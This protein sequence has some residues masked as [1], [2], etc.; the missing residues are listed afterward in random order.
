MPSKKLMRVKNLFPVSLAVAAYLLAPGPAAAAEKTVEIYLDGIPTAIS[1]PEDFEFYSVA[2]EDIGAGNQD[3]LRL[4]GLDQGGSLAMG[5]AYSEEG[6]NKVGAE[7][8]GQWPNGVVVNSYRMTNEYSPTNWLDFEGQYLG[9]DAWNL[10][11]DHSSAS[12]SLDSQS[13]ER[14]GW[15]F[16]ADDDVEDNPVFTASQRHRQQ[17]WL[18]LRRGSMEGG[19]WAL[20]LRKYDV[21][22]QDPELDDPAY[23]PKDVYLRSG[24]LEH[25]GRERGWAFELGAEYG[26][27]ASKNALMD[28]TYTDLGA[29]ALSQLSPSLALSLDASLRSVDARAQDAQAAYTKAGA[30]LDWELGDCVEVGA[31]LRLHSEADDVVANSNLR[32]FSEMSADLRYR[33]DRDFT[34]EARLRQRDFE[35]ERLKLEDQAFGE[36]YSADPP[37]TRDELE[38]YREDVT[39][40]SSRYELEARWRINC[41]LSLHAAYGEESFDSLPGSA[42]MASAE[43]AAQLSRISMAAGSAP[44]EPFLPDQR[45]WGDLR[46]DYEVPCGGRFSF[47]TGHNE[48]RN[49]P[50]ASGH[51]L[52]RYALNYSDALDECRRWQAG[53]SRVESSVDLPLDELDQ[54]AE[55]WNYSLSLS[56]EEARL[57]YRLSYDHQ[58]TSGFAGGEYDGVGLELG[59]RHCPLYLSGWWRERGKTGWGGLADYDDY[60]VNLGY[61]WAIN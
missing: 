48:M 51:E 10:E 21:E 19:S 59:L 36:L 18:R 23:Q 29:E 16:G 49:G 14:E 46:L 34:L 61:R 2:R 57:N 32:S 45:S 6:D 25:R 41:R 7:K 12:W 33:P 40:S 3:L 31:G 37:P 56:G 60:G 38:E 39:S 35:L 42:D 30:R 17:H 27:Y 55:S 53:V 28:N 15:V 47:V 13:F 11:L 24:R 58:S 22:R 4:A 1:V 20:D 52:S 8:Y 44:D 54:N 9:P 50:R 26:Q 43:S 5:Y